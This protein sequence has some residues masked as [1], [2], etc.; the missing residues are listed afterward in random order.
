VFGQ[1]KQ[2]REFRQFLLRGLDTAKAEWALV[3]TVYNLLKLAALA[4]R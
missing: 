1:I 2:A 4:E 3:C